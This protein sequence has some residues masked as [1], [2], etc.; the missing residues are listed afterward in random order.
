MAANSSTMRR[1]ARSTQTKQEAAKAQLSSFIHK[2]MEPLPDECL[3]DT[4]YNSMLRQQRFTAW[5]AILKELRYFEAI[6]NF[7]LY[8]FDPPEPYRVP[9]LKLAQ[10]Q[11]YVDRYRDVLARLLLTP[12]PSQL[13]LRWKR[14]ELRSMSGCVPVK[15]EDVEASIAADEVFLASHPTRRSSGSQRK[16]AL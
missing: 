15:R 7:S 9:G 1:R 14:Q 3:V 6:S 12:S 10:R 11:V 4:Q 2:V 8:S 13:E 16:E 5:R